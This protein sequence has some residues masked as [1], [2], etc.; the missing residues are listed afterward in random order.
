MSN[1]N[2]KV[3]FIWDL[4][5]LIR[6]SYK[7]SEYQDVIL[8]FVVLKR[9]DSVL[10]DTKK[11]VVEKYEFSKENNIENFDHLLRTVSNASFYNYSRYDFKSLLEDPD[12]I[13]QNLLHYIDSFSQNVQD[14]FENFEIK[15]QIERLAKANL[16]FKLV[17]KFNNTEIDLHP[18]KVDNH[19]MGLIFEELVRK[20]AESSNEEA[21]EHFTPRDV[22]D[23]MTHLMFVEDKDEIQGEHVIKRIYDPACWTWGMLSNAKRYIGENIN[24]KAE[25]ILYWQ[26]INPKTYAV[27]K[28]DML[29]KWDEANNIRWP[30]STLGKDAF[31]WEKFDYIL[32]NP[33]YW[34]KWEADKEEVL[35]E[36]ELWD[37]GRFGAWTPRINDWQ[38]LFLQHMISK[39]KTNWEKSRISVITN[40]SPLFTW[41]AW[42]WESEIRKFIIEN[43]YLEAIIALPWQLFYNT[44]I[45]TYIWILSNKKEQKRKGKIQLID[46]TSFWKKMRK[47]LWDK[48]RE[49]D[50]IE[51]QQKIIELYHEFKNNEFSRIFDN[52]EFAYTKVVVER[53]MQLNFQVSEERLENLY[54][55][56]TFAK[57]SESKSK[58][59]EK[60][61]AEEQAWTEKQN[62]IIENLKTIWDKIFTNHDEF[63]SKVEEVLKWFDFKPTFIKQIV[64]ALSEHDDN[65]PF[66]VDKKWNKQ[67][68]WDLRDN[69]KIKLTEDIDDYF[70]RE[71]I[72]YYPEA[73]M[74]RSKDKIGY[75][76][77]FTKY[78][79]KYEPPRNLEDI[80]VDI[81]SITAEIDE[82]VKEE[83]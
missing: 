26:E 10:F 77:N 27:A 11:K 73:W 53:P 58:D 36:A 4:A 23:L 47:S 13:E 80:E 60:K 74:D 25:L 32:S 63:Y 7:R 40:G 52:N 29:L 37:Q 68:N 56:S 20:F 67:A 35:A 49:L 28:S 8:P 76:I 12:H 38:L 21:W 50:P 71:V 44:G 22:I 82:L 79:Y 19:E 65:A 51:H 3:S 18:D 54:S 41:D 31:S 5:D 24:Q 17:K 48:R 59:I 64:K 2:E 61:I 66:I 33:P 9:F 83:L 78:F 75:E 57:F 15:K 1:F 42:S 34:T 72:P 43:D 30:F 62:T 70:E 46:W 16:L 14:I 55:I 69:E 6:G 39:M 45:G 81:K